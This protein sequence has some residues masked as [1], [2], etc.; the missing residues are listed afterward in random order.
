MTGQTPAR[1]GLI[2]CGHIAQ[3]YLRW[4]TETYDDRLAVVACTDTDQRRADETA[5]RFKLNVVPDVDTLLRRDDVEIVLNVTNP[6]AHTDVTLAALDA[7][8][9]V[10]S[11]KPL[12]LS[13][14]D[15][16]RIV[17]RARARG[18]LVA[19]AP[20][21]MLG[22]PQRTAWQWIREGRLGTIHEVILAVTTPGHEAWHPDPR[23]YYQ[24]GAG[25]LLDLGVYSLTL[26]TTILGPI[27][28]VW[29][30]AGIAIPVR[31]I[32]TGP[33]AGERFAVEV[34]DHVTGFMRFESGVTGMIHASFA[35]AKT[36]MPPVE[37]HGSDGSLWL[38]DFHRFDA[39]VR[40]CMRGEEEW[41]ALPPRDP[42]AAPNW[43]RAIVD[44]AEAA[45]EGRRPRMAAEQAAHV[46]EVMLGIEQSARE[47]T[48]EIAI[49]RRF[50]PPL[51]LDEHDPTWD[52]D[53]RHG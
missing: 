12:A 52:A 29:G 3:S 15:A 19:C 47:G 32:A 51:P 37:L 36:T 25:P 40:V 50:A 30:Q 43:A 48:R 6:A 31:A 49:A 21:I 26:A 13:L 10:F 46:L 9:H 14:D 28:H 45:R 53:A 39:A 44:L 18:L 4:I 42:R 23:Y 20:S 8:K 33:R 35:V 27:T 34:S 24:S 17:D 1:L 5:A 11:E 41:R 16:D 7:G 22:A 2:G 38:D